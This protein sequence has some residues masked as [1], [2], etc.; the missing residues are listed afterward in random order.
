MRRRRNNFKFTEK[1]HSKRGIVSICVSSVMILLY[2]AFIF[3]SSVGRGNL[4]AYYGSVGVMAML[5][6][7]VSLVL[8]IMGLKEEDSFKILSRI[9][10]YGSAIAVLLW[11][12]TYIFGFVG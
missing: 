12:G 3:L 6:S 5:V 7:V 2:I 9:G 10:L 1:T 4:S 11:L 8:S